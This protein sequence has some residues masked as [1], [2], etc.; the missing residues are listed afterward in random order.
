MT[1]LGAYITGRSFPIPMRAQPTLTMD[2]SGTESDELLWCDDDEFVAT[3]DEY[4]DTSQTSLVSPDQGSEAPATVKQEP[5]EDLDE[6]EDPVA[7]EHAIRVLEEWAMSML[8]EIVDGY[9]KSKFEFHLASC[10]KKSDTNRVRKIVWPSKRTPTLK[11]IGM[12]FSQT[13]VSVDLDAAHSRDSQSSRTGTPRAQGRN[14][15][16]KE[17]CVLWR[18]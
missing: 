14:P 1:N 5:V 10:R 2:A 11:T 8:E 4:I 9:D 16:H 3:D 13:R 15:D 12:S 18:R 7:N 17:G 6:L